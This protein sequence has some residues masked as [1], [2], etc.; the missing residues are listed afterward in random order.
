MKKLVATLFIAAALTSCKVPVYTIGM[1]E[2]EFKAQNKFTDL[3]Q[4]TANHTIYRNLDHW[5]D[6][7]QSVYKFYYFVDGKLVRIDEDERHGK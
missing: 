2:A 1:T 3:Y 7:G 4:A 5:D 6:K